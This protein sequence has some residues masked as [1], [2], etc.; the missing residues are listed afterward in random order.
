MDSTSQTMD[1]QNPIPIRTGLASLTLLT[2]QL[3]PMKRKSKKNM[4]LWRQGAKLS[5]HWRSYQVRIIRPKF[6]VGLQYQFLRKET[7]PA[8]IIYASIFIS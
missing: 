5:V 6:Y 3:N 4:C 1:G 7:K 8:V 2:V